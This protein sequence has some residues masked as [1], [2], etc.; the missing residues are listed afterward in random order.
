MA[1]FPDPYNSGPFGFAQPRSQPLDYGRETTPAVAAFFNAVYAWMAAGLALTGVVAWFTYQHPEVLRSIG[2]IGLIVLFLVEL[3][4]VFA[5]SGA[6]NRISASAATALFLVYSAI[7][8]LFLSVLF[9]IY[10]HG[11]IASTFLVT[12]G[13]F[14]ATSVYGYVTKAD[15][16][17]IGSIAFM[18]LI[19]L[20]LASVVNIFLRSP[21][22][23]WLISYAG[24]LIFTALTA[25]DTQK[26][27][28]I[29]Y[30]TAGD[31]RLS[32]RLAISGSLALYL[33][34]IN[35]FIFLL[36]IMG[37]RRS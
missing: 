27:K 13:A 12:A 21:A 23:Y 32:A 35:L 37:N 20:I 15:L 8:G 29:A 18:A 11:S 26:L 33:D 34:F 1:R 36:R 3:G 17:R 19:G 2:G 5:I 28:E 7:N 24:V 9:A 16:T 25:Y 30:Q 10:T 4:L 31:P 22:M 14:A 6:V